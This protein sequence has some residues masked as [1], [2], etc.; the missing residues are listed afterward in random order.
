M[1]RSEQEDRL[2]RLAD[3]EDLQSRLH[4]RIEHRTG[5]RA[6]QLDSSS[7]ARDRRYE[8][9]VH[10]GGAEQFR[11]E[12]IPEVVRSIVSERPVDNNNFA[13]SFRSAPR[14]ST[15]RDG[16]AAYIVGG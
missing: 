11:I 5:P 13:E 9:D 1:S 10:A 14:S 3:S 12:H 16:G 8:P 15:G 6:H 4:A 2:W 7:S